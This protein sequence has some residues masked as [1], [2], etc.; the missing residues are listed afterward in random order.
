MVAISWQPA[1]GLRSLRWSVELVGLFV[2]VVVAW[3][4]QKN[5]EQKKYDSLKHT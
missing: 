1:G 4:R 3:P 2:L 5:A